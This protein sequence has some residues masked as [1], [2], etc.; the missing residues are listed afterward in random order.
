MKRISAKH[1]NV[2]VQISGYYGILIRVILNVLL[3]IAI[4]ALV[5]C[6]FKSGQDLWNLR[7]MQLEKILQEILLD[8]VF[9]VALVEVINTIIGYLRDGK[10]HVRFI[11]DTVLIIMLNEVVSAWFKHESFERMGSLA[12]IIATLTAARIGVTLFA[13][14]KKDDV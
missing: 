1:F 7:N 11:I 5:L 12:L 9:I 3:A 14:D 2:F 4:A 6:V 8:V 13:P 10:V